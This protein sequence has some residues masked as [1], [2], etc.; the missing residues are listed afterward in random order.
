VRL[1]FDQI[2]AEKSAGV[3][4]KL[5]TPIGKNKKDLE[6][7]IRIY[8]HKNPD[9]VRQ[10]VDFDD[11]LMADRK[12]TFAVALVGVAKPALLDKCQDGYNNCNFGKYKTPCSAYKCFYE[13]SYP[14]EY[15]ITAPEGY[16]YWYYLKLK[17]LPLLESFVRSFTEP[18]QTDEIRMVNDKLREKEHYSGDLFEYC[19][20]KVFEKDYKEIYK[21][22]FDLFNFAM[23]TVIDEYKKEIDRKAEIVAQMD[24][25]GHG[26]ERPKIAGGK[27]PTPQIDADK[28]AGAGGVDAGKV[29]YGNDE[30]EHKR[31]VSQIFRHILQP[32]DKG[33]N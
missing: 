6:Q 32:V 17:G 24:K 7:M 12:I 26:G 25:G 10:I 20:D 33:R 19:G 29:A 4:K 27:K 5:T 13:A 31:S 1:A 23:D 30:P 2:E 28:S 14:G 16:H 11:N 3:W 22:S 8:T 9:Y 18:V 15:P 21:K